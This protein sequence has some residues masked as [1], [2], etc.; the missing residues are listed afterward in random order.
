MVHA[1][2]PRKKFAWML[3]NVEDET[4]DAALALS[5]RTTWDDLGVP[6]FDR[7]VEYSA[8]V[9][10]WGLI[11]EALPMVRLGAPACTELAAAFAFLTGTHP[12]PARWEVD[13]IR[14]INDLPRQSE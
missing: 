2:G 4:V 5:N 11:E 8:K 13:L 3:D 9:V 12:A 7:G 10:A 6:W 1:T 14:A